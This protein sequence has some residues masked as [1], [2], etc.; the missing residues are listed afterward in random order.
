[1][2]KD[3]DVGIGLIHASQSLIEEALRIAK[4]N[5]YNLLVEPYCI[6]AAIPAGRRM[7]ADGIDV[8]VSRRHT[9]NVLRN[10]LN[11]PVL[12]IPVTFF[13]TY[14][15]IWKASKRWKSIL[16]P[17]YKGSSERK[18]GL[19]DMIDAD[20]YYYEYEST[21]QMEDAILWGKQQRCQGVV[22]GPITKNFALKH[23]MEYEEIFMSSESVEFTLREAYWVA[24]NR[25]KEKEQTH[26]YKTIVNMDD[27]YVIAVNQYGDINI[28]S[29]RAKDFFGI[30]DNQKNPRNI[31][32]VLPVKEVLN[33]IEHGQTLKFHVERIGNN[34]FLI[35]YMPTE[36]G[37][38]A[39][40]GIITLQN[41]EVVIKAENEIR[42]STAKRL[43]AKYSMDEFIYNNPEMATLITTVKKYA[44]RE[45]TILIMGPTGTGKEIMAHAI[46]KLSRQKAGPFVSIN[47]ASI[48]E[49]LLES[50]LFGYEE[51]SFTG[52]RRRGKAGLFELAH[53]GTIFL[54]E[55][56]SMP[57]NLQAR[58]LRVLQEK[59][60]MRVGGD[61]LIPVDAR[62]LA[63][64]NEDLKKSVFNGRFR[65]DLFFRINVLI[66]YIPPL[67]ERIQDIP[68][69]IRNLTDKLSRKHDLPA[70]KIPDP[71]I[72]M[73]STLSWPGNVRELSNFIERL[74]I[75]CEGQ[76]SH[77]IFEK[78]YVELCE[79]SKMNSGKAESDM[80]TP[81]T[82]RQ[83][84]QSGEA[85]FILKVLQESRYNKTVAAQRLGISRVTL[86]RKMK[87][88]PCA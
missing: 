51:G 64:T 80:P 87:N 84:N 63:A 66:I 15:T 71:C 75:I 82:I 55:I 17:I 1:M 76:F 85:N 38:K 10:N 47:C 26:L 86:W 24:V 52:A 56:G 33:C 13:D 28:I 21:S 6:E 58:L 37:N 50:E 74:I 42:R 53:K 78:Q 45:S 8:I 16:F 9:A 79:Y 61:R 7:E 12:S 46:H 43:V 30:K 19:K 34:Q 27:K 14:Q 72:E 70:I 62:V 81:K 40:G 23:G 67:R 44:Y 88:L 57:L 69:L 11:I 49:Q 36:L 77:D 3:T 41:T 29:E 5:N 31:K 18:I 20:I 68:P 4:K 83:D 32:S 22:A 60:V 54:D 2:M 48:P 35:D 25:N 65:E 73:L 39:I 59:E